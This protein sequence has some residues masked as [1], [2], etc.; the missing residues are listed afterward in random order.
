MPEPE[1]KVAVW[2]VGMACPHCGGT[3]LEG[4]DCAFCGARLVMSDLTE[5]EEE[6]PFESVLGNYREGFSCI[7]IAKEVMELESP[8]FLKAKKSTVP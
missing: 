1:P 5:G 8:G 3:K 6:D 7:K 2:S 4:K